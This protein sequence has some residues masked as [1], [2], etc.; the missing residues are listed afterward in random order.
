MRLCAAKHSDRLEESVGI[1]RLGQV[2]IEA[3]R[4]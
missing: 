2:L 1:C 3:G 4:S